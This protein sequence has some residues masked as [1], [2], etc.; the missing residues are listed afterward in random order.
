MTVVRESPAS[1]F[2]KALQAAGLDDAE[3]VENGLAVR[4]GGV[5]IW[6]PDDRLDAYVW[7][8]HCQHTVAARVGLPFAATQIA[9]SLA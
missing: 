7:G 5:T 1:K 9:R 8:S 2:V 6:L 4:A 3:A